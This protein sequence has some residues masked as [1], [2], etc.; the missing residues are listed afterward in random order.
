MRGV[1]DGAEAPQ[2]GLDRRPTAAG[3]D[4]RH[5]TSRAYAFS[6]RIIPALA[7]SG[8]RIA[9]GPAVVS[10]APRGRTH[11]RTRPRRQ[12]SNR[13]CVEGA[14]HTKTLRSP[15][16]AVS[17]AGPCAQEHYRSRASAQ[18]AAPRALPR[19]T[20]SA[21][22]LGHRSIQGPGKPRG[23]RRAIQRQATKR[24]CTRSASCRASWLARSGVGSR[25]ARGGAYR[26]P[27]RVLDG[28]VRQA[29]NAFVAL[30]HGHIA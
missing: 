19:S 10:T 8:L 4:P 12:S 28:P 17:F 9:S 6:R 14:V 18:W 29:G 30:V 1:R 11:D 23:K 20:R 26:P 24:R 2:A 16:L 7:S 27:H 3:R 22:A 5:T 25:P 21:V 15:G 13:P